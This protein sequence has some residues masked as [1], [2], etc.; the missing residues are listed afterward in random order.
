MQINII[1]VGTRLPDWAETAYSD[2][3]R[4]FPRE[5]SVQLHAV[6]A[7]P[8]HSRTREQLVAAEQTRIEAKR[9]KNH[10]LVVLD[11]RGS[12]LSTRRFAAQLEKW[13]MSGRGVDIV[14][15]GPDGTAAA[16]RQQADMCIRLSE[17]TLPHALAR[18]VLAEQLY[19]A[20]SL[21]AGHP[22]HRE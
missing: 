21:S 12:T 13:Q 17:M 18:V 1:A 3:A 22:Y 10:C 16:F 20:W 4:R 19:R 8:R 5:L 11:E 2:Y 15:G 9:G 14:I 6:R 7:E